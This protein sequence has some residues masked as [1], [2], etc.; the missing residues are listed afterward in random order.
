MALE[1]EWRLGINTNNIELFFPGGVL[2]T[3]SGLAIYGILKLTGQSMED[4][5]RNSYRLQK[6]RME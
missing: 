6:S 2:G 5:R 3:I 4:V 1:I